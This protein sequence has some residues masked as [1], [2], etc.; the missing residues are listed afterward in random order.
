[1]AVNNS[2]EINDEKEIEEPVRSSH[3]PQLYKSV[4]Y[5]VM[6]QSNSVGNQTSI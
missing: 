3:R 4:K 1:M 6:R 2:F 5:E